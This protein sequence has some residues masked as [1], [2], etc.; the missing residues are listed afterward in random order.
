MDEFR[1]ERMEKALSTHLYR[2]FLTYMECA[3]PRKAKQFSP[4]AIFLND[5]WSA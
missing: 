1:E 4:T 3:A 2:V 5:E